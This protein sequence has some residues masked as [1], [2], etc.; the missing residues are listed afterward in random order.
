MAIKR[1]GTFSFLESARTI[2]KLRG[3]FG[4]AVLATK[5]SPA[6]AAAVD[7]LALACAA[8]EA[9]DDHPG[10]TD[11][12]GAQTEYADTPAPLPNPEPLPVG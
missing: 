7:A 3:K 6:F 9:L 1:D 2:C 12:T 11:D 8:F 4:T 10:E 5:V